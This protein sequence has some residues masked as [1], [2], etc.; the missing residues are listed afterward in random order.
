MVE[1]YVDLGKQIGKEMNIKLPVA[2]L[3]SLWLF[4][5]TYQNPGKMP[6][7]NRN[8]P[9]SSTTEKGCKTEDVAGN[10]I[11][12]YLQR[13]PA[14]I[15]LSEL[16]IFIIDALLERLLFTGKILPRATFWVHLS[17]LWVQ[18]FTEDNVVCLSWGRYDHLYPSKTATN[19]KVYKIK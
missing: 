3:F 9:D 11:C 16:I 12:L 5:R 15:Q 7:K 4:Q 1:K 17:S 10:F 19:R 6:K 13:Q 2:L 18:R 14:D 8:Y